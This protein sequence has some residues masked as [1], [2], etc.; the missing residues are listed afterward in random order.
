MTDAEFL[1]VAKSQM[2]NNGNLTRALAKKMY[3]LV[4]QSPRR[5]AQAHALFGDLGLYVCTT[6]D[7]QNFM[8]ETEFNRSELD[9][10]NYSDFDELL[11]KTRRRSKRWKGGD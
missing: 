2:Y 1:E 9:E 10:S 7:I 3:F 4:R 11:I 8:Y 5:L 6:S